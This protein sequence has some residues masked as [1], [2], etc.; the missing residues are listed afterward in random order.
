MVKNSSEKSNRKGSGVIK[1]IMLGFYV[2]ST[3]A[4]WKLGKR[5]QKGNE[6]THKTKKR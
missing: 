5:D 4:F 1:A 2:S 3:A 6:G